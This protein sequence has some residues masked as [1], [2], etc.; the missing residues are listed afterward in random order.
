MQRIIVHIVFALLFVAVQI[1]AFQ[2]PLKSDGE[3]RDI[4]EQV[5]NFE[6][7]AASTVHFRSIFTDVVSSINKAAGLQYFTIKPA[8]NNENSDFKIT[9]SL[10]SDL[11][12]A[13]S[14]YQLPASSSSL[15]TF[16]YSADCLNRLTL[17]ETPP[18][19]FFG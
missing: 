8:K 5:Q 19:E 15:H 13:Q 12:L 17:P 3:L 4:I 2:S 1:P 10:K 16:S 6:N 7:N 18:P 9:V 11:L 14:T